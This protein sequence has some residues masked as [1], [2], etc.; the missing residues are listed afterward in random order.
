MSSAVIL[1][2]STSWLHMPRLVTSK[3]NWFPRFEVEFSWGNISSSRIRVGMPLMWWTKGIAMRLVR[4]FPCSRTGMWCMLFLQLRDFTSQPL[5]NTLA[6]FVLGG[7][8]RISHHHS[9]VH[10]ASWRLSL[11]VIPLNPPQRSTERV[12]IR[13]AIKQMSSHIFQCR[14][15]TSPKH[16]PQY[17]VGFGLIYLS[18]INSLHQK[19]FQSTTPSRHI[20]SFTLLSTIKAS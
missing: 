14:Q 18:C 5:N 6:F 3:T 17:T 10:L 7:F 4:R 12:K 13:N 16:I 9:R 15:E 20:F 19:I 2:H 8:S 1:S 11:I